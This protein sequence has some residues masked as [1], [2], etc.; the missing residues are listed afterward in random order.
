MFLATTITFSLFDFSFH[1]NLSICLLISANAHIN[2][3]DYT[4]HIDVMYV[5][6]VASY[7]YVKHF[8]YVL[9]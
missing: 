6:I 8:H 2:M 1:F 9:K 5:D 4:E 7:L 3:L